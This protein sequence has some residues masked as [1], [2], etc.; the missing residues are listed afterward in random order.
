MMGIMMPETCWDKSLIINI[1]LVTSSWFLSL[2]PMFM[3]H[4][5]KSLKE[6]KN[7]LSL[8]TIYYHQLQKICLLFS[9]ELLQNSIYLLFM[10]LWKKMSL[11]KHCIVVHLR[12]SAKEN[13]YT[14]KTG[15]ERGWWELRS[16]RSIIC[17]LK[18]NN[19]SLIRLLNQNREYRDRSVFPH[20]YTEL[21]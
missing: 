10:F 17:A 11:L 5:H 8:K 18:T 21:I 13:V 14:Q 19:V 20:V 4:G 9:N 6:V 16:G 7:K 3:M 15:G 12:R 2:H 1:R